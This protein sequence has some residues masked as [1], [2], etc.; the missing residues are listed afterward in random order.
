MPLI[1]ENINSLAMVKHTMKLIKRAVDNLNKDQTPVVTADQP[2][3]ALGKQV[4][5]HFVHDYGEDKFV[6][7]MG[8]LRD[9]EHDGT[10]VRRK[11]ME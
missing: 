3:Y 7:M 9:L 4:Q 11:W 1:N 6:F 8:G 2:V 5:W 10:L